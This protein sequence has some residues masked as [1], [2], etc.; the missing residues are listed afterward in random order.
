MK[1]LFEFAK[2]LNDEQLFFY[3]VFILIALGIIANMISNIVHSLSKPKFPKKDGK[4]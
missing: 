1:Y 2:T 4:V 3:G